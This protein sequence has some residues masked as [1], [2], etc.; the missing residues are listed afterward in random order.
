MHLFRN[1]LSYE[2]IKNAMNEGFFES[3]T[4][5]N[6]DAWRM[7]VAAVRHNFEYGSVL[8]RQLLGVIL[9]FVP[10]SLWHSKPIGSG[11]MLIQSEFGSDIF[12]NVSCPLVAEGYVNFGFFG[13][14]IFG[15]ILGL[16]VA[17]LDVFYWNIFEKEKQKSLF[18][19]YL[20]LVFM[21]FFVL[22]GDLLS[23]FAYVCGFVG[24]GILLRPFNVKG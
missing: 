8:G 21:L 20:F 19:P 12:S 16:F 15:L 5:G 18:S 1:Y 10:S 9:F 3:Y 24:T 23:G 14:V 13:V 6:Y 17:K 2:S 4:D 7:L 11:A 22:R